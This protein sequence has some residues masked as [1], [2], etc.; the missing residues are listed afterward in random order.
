MSTRVHKTH[1]SDY[2]PGF[3]IYQ[4]P[5]P[6]FY[7]PQRIRDLLF[8]QRIASG[9]KRLE[10]M[11]CSTRVLHLWH[12][13]FEPA[14]YA[15]DFD[16]SVYHIDDEYSF[17][18]NAPAVSPQEARVIKEVDQVFAISPALMERKQG[19]NDNLTFVPEGVDA[20]WYATPANE[21][22]DL[23][24]V[25][26]PRIGYTGNLKQQ[27]DWP[28]LLNLARRRPD[29]S[30]VFVGPRRPVPNF[31]DLIDELASY[32][33]VYMLG[34]KE[35]SELAAYV[36]HFDVCVMPYNVD[37]YT[38]NIYPLKLHEY[39]AT[40]RP[41]VGSPIRSLIDFSEV[42]SL[43]SG[44]ED[45]L[46]ALSDSLKPTLSSPSWIKKRQVVARRNDWQHLIRQMV[47]TILNKLESKGHVLRNVDLSLLERN[48]ENED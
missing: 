23:K 15:R 29:W 31:E 27:L 25:P 21:P 10:R 39:L 28:L 17:S 43:A 11:G 2:L 48:F 34:E 33:N 16:L 3:Q 38:E 37:S 19:L 9:W 46:I 24:S 7:R 26:G 47:T 32:E 8:R 14:L 18:P 6:D 40:G 12:P 5:I 41:V 45:W 44:L 13:R 20:G 42:I 1:Y 36:Q 4:S 35:S 22:S 30:F